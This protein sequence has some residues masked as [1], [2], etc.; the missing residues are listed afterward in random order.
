MYKESIS[1]E[2]SFIIRSLFWWYIA[3]RFSRLIRV[4]CLYCLLFLFDIEFKIRDNLLFV[5]KLI[6]FHKGGIIIEL[7]HFLKIEIHNIIVKTIHCSC[8]L[9]DYSRYR[10]GIT[11][12]VDSREYCH[13]K[14]IRVVN[15]VQCCV[16]T[17]HC[18]TS[19]IRRLLLRPSWRRT[20]F[21]LPIPISILKLFVPSIFIL[22]EVLL[23][24]LSEYW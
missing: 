8:N 1:Y 10:I 4:F 24:F 23:G 12:P 17:V 19:K 15:N 6:S 9:S 14:A 3:F 20:V 18:I 2:I 11:P 22:L 13:L 16:Q 5:E 21:S 7:D